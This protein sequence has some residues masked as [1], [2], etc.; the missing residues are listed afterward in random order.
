MDKSNV[1]FR[2]VADIY[3]A[4]HAKLMSEHK[5]PFQRQ[6]ERNA[7]ESLITL[8][9]M[10]GARLYIAATALVALPIMAFAGEGDYILAVMA[11]LYA[12]LFVYGNR[13]RRSA[14][15][16]TTRRSLG[17]WIALYSFF[18][19]GIMAAMAIVLMLEPGGWR[20]VS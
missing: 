1:S 16:G 3:G 18:L 7:A 8:G 11:A 15:K 10:S 2:A 17:F 4:M 14:E 13:I 6:L 9:G 19:A 20:Y 5:S 12:V